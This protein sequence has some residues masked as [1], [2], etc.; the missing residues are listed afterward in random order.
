M[1]VLIT[2]SAGMLGSAV[3]PAFVEAGYDTVATDLNPR[4]VGDLP[5]GRLDVRDFPAL[6]AAVERE[7]PDLVLHL[8]AETDLET[9]ENNPDH[10]YLTN[11][12]GTQYAAITCQRRGLPMVYISTAG[13]FDGAVRDRPYTEF[14]APN[15]INVYGDSKYQGERIVQTLVPQHYVIRAGWMVG[16]ADRDHKFVAKIADQLR[17]GAKTIYAVTDKLGTPTYTR[18]FARNLLALVRTPYYGLYHMACQGRGS[19]FD[20]ARELLDY[21]GRDDVTVEPVTSDFFAETFPAPRP[22]SEMMRNY[23]LE[24]RGMNLMRPWQ[25]ALRDYLDQA[26]FDLSAGR[27]RAAAKPAR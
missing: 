15:P 27:P 12:V 1:R 22:Y 6:D 10:A 25:E 18:D 11:T 4:P 9:S 3:Y 8:A 16:G 2:G 19:R 24:L 5:M 17:K 23:M 13:V 14:D 21:Y 20:V 7:R 26:A